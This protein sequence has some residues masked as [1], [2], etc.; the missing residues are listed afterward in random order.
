MDAVRSTEDDMRSHAHRKK[1]VCTPVKE[2][3]VTL[4]ALIDS[5]TLPSPDMAWKDAE[6]TLL[7][8]YKSTYHRHE[9]FAALMKHSHAEEGSPLIVQAT[10]PFL[11][12]PLLLRMLRHYCHTGVVQFERGAAVLTLL[13]YYSACE[14]Y[15]LLEARDVMEAAVLHKM[16]TSSALA[17]FNNLNGTL[18]S[19]TPLMHD[20]RCFIQEHILDVL[21][22]ST[23]GVA[24][25][26]SSSTIVALIDLLQ[27]DCVNASE[28]ELLESLYNFCLKRCRGD[29][30]QAT[31]LLFRDWS[32]ESLE[33]ESVLRKRSRSVSEESVTSSPNSNG[34]CLW[35]CIRHNGL[36]YETVLQFRRR[37][38]DALPDKFYLDLFEDIAHKTGKTGRTGRV[39]SAYPRTLTLPALAEGSGSFAV[40]AFYSTHLTVTYIGVQYSRGAAVRVPPFCG[41]DTSVLEMMVMFHQQNACI[42]GSVDAGVQRQTLRHEEVPSSLKISVQ[43]VNFRHD[44]WRK[45]SIEGVGRAGA[46]FHLQKLVSL[47][48]LEQEGYSFDVGAYPLIKPGRHILLKIVTESA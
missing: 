6:S 23:N 45:V 30:V 48:T 21:N 2:W 40:N 14:A 25:R 44:R 4:A 29:K 5:N 22:K 13:K 38:P 24:H 18:L 10:G 42:R 9:F 35:S 12:D 41:A 37:C 34:S 20:I 28:E 8:D 11:S 47:S 26:L 36:G 7:Y 19:D 46:R 39:T 1:S 17:A 32:D 3:Q 16:D 31:R 27:D 43:I 15:G 33:A